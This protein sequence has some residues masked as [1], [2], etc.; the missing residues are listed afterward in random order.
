MERIP[1]FRPWLGP[2][3]KAAVAEVLDSGRLQ[4]GE[5]VAAFEEAFCKVSGTDHAVAVASGSSA[6]SLALHALKLPRSAFVH[7]SPL[8]YVSTGS[9]VVQ[10][11]LRLSLSDISLA[12][13][14]LDDD[15]VEPALEGGEAALLPVHLYG[16]PSPMDG[17]LEVAARRGLKV[18]ED[19]AQAVGARY[20]GRPVGSMGDLGCFSFNT[21]KIVTTGEGG[22]V[23]TNDEKLAAAVRVARDLG[24]RGK[25]YEFEEVGANLRM[26]EVEGAIGTEQVKKL[27]A[28]LGARRQTAA[29]YT[30]RLKG[31]QGLVLP[32]EP[33]GLE[34]AWYQYTVRALG[35][36]RDA[37]RAHLDREGVDTGVYY[38][39]ALHQLGIF[40][41]VRHGVLG[42]CEMACREVLS[43]PVHPG[44]GPGERGRVAAAVRGFF[45]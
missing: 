38:A 29:F 39:T 27:P 23:T 5:R 28:S 15:H 3:E 20:K 34:H 25:G 17:L 10:A 19:C 42:R 37:L 33:P 4:Q 43:I 1:I 32:I 35:G 9:A 40:E 13:Y 36:K 30:E 14:N 18:V 41:G 24:R 8:T 21:Q 11:G 12:S 44:V 7:T 31:L 22:M 26:S 16:L 45:T 2:E 6:L